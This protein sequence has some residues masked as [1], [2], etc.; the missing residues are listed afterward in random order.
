MTGILAVQGDFAEHAR[1]LERIGEPSFEIRSPADLIRPFD[2]L[3]LPGGEST[4]QSLLIKKLGLFDQLRQF[5]EA[6]LPVLATCAG[7]ILLSERS[8]DSEGCCF[9]TLPVRVRRNAYGRQL[10][11]FS[12]TGTFSDIGVIPME[13]IRAPYIESA[14][15]TVT[16][17]SVTDGHIIAVVYKNQLALSFHPELT[18]DDRLY[19]WWLTKKLQQY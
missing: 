14:A 9:R 17:K 7:M 1:S 6:G 10:G 16:V 4:V 19:R 11:S 3:I 13:F 18:D 12:T 2:R 15:D 5:I 8:G